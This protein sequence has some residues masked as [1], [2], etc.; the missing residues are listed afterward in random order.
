MDSSRH[1]KKIF[2]VFISENFYSAILKTKCTPISLCAL[3]L[4]NIR[5][6]LQMFVA[7][8]ISNKC[9]LPEFFHFCTLTSS[10]KKLCYIG[11]SSRGFFQINI[12]GI[13]SKIR[14]GILRNLFEDYP[15]SFWNSSTSSFKP[16]TDSFGNLLQVFL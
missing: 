14:Y 11:T 10:K 16:T 9:K 12:S 15:I 2:T 1:L 6:R 7:K 3:T 13:L 4:T 8:C 5:N